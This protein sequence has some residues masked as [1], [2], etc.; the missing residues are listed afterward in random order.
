MLSKKFSIFAPMK[1]VLYLIRFLFVLLSL[2]LILGDCGVLHDS[3]S[4]QSNEVQRECSDTSRDF[5]H[6]NSICLEDDLAIHDKMVNVG[7]C[8]CNSNNGFSCTA[9]LNNSYIGCIWQPPK[10][11]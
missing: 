7:S 2:I 10:V 9:H 3:F 8:I 1:R 6:M 11:S 5:G 4:F